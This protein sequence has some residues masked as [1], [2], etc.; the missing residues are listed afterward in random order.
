[1][2]SN[3]PLLIV[4]VTLVAGVALVVLEAIAPLGVLTSAPTGAPSSGGSTLEWRVAHA[5]ARL[6]MFIGAA[7]VMRWR[8]RTVRSERPVWRWLSRAAWLGA[9]AAAAGGA[10]EIGEAAG[11]AV[12]SGVPD[13]VLS[14]GVL[15][16]CPLLYQGLVRWNR[17]GTLTSDPGDWLNGVSAVLTLTALGNLLLPWLHSPLMQW[18]SWQLQLWLLRV[19][20]EAMLVGTITTV[21]IIGSL[22]SDVRAWAMTIALTLVTVLDVASLGDA[23]A[24]AGG[25][26]VASLGWAVSTLVL[27]GAAVLRA[28]PPLLRPVT[29]TA[30]TMGSLIVLVASI[31]VLVLPAMLRADVSAGAAVWVG[32]W[33]GLGALGVTLR[34]VQ[35]IRLLAD[36]VLTRHEALTD[37]LTGLANRRAL[38]ARLK[39]DLDA[40]RSFSLMILDLNDFKQ[41]NDRFGHGV[42]DELLRRTG[43]LLRQVAGTDAFTARLGGD[44]F[45]ITLPSASTTDALKVTAALARIALS[46]VI[47]DGHRLFVAG[48]IGIAVTQPGMTCEELL[49]AADAAMYRAKRAGGGVRVHDDAAAAQHREQAQ[50]REEIKALLGTPDAAVDVDPGTLVVH[51]QAQLAASGLVAGA[52]ALVRWQ[53]PRLGLLAPDA[54]LHLVEDFGLMSALTT[55]VMWQA[56]R[57]AAHWNSAGHDL[58]ISVNLSATSL[59]HPDLPGLVDDVLAVTLL[60]PS[61]LVLEVTETS[62]MAHPEE[63]VR[64]LIEL[65]A[66]GVD[67]SIDDYGSGHSSLAY[68]NDLPAAELKIDRSLTQHITSNARTADIVAGTIALAH[69]LG[70]RIVAEGVEDVETL[71]MLRDLDCDE[72][73]GYLHG[74]PVSAEDFSTWLAATTTTTMSR[75]AHGPPLETAPA[76]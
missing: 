7:V 43:A 39:G 9:A 44:E 15:L 68:L 56:S 74:R 35:L 51:Y 19:S 4:A 27:A 6:L 25:R 54:F 42:G 20:A 71:T 21:L 34:G 5:A 72:T 8:A 31:S 30:P 67:I 49:S 61:R 11:V 36:L 75:S 1:M 38:D 17:Y 47:I 22:L 32:A 60:H 18:P 48:S 63:S 16:A 40:D 14:A 33:A 29:S 69:R 64:R 10:L 57:Q 59:T 73:Q 50:L 23:T 26:H 52:E 41:V 24:A 70:L 45:A 65:A 53:H 2:I 28:A 58:R 12:G 46:P 66:K 62:V 76:L 3:A 13:L 55:E 37:E